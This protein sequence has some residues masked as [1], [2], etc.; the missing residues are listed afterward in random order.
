MIS[1]AMKTHNTL[2]E[3]VMFMMTLISAQAPRLRL[4]MAGIRVVGFVYCYLNGMIASADSG[5]LL[6]RL[7][8]K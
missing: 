8:M 7:L 5:E 3:A 1:R 4:A 6:M 2:A